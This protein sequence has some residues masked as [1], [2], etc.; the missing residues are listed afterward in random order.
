MAELGFNLVAVPIVGA[1]MRT[2]NLLLT[3]SLSRLEGFISYQDSAQTNEIYNTVQQVVA[4]LPV[5]SRR[6]VQTKIVVE[7]GETVVMGGLIDT[8]KQE[9]DHGVPFVSSIP[10]L[11][12]LF[13]RSTTTEE[14]RNL[15]VFVTATVLSERGET[16][17]VKTPLGPLP[18]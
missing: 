17:R 7:S 1:D 12:K 11:G 5:I 18:P 3:P 10:L 4:K 2:I 13:N 15:L 16:L 6:E 14:Q 9:T 8:V